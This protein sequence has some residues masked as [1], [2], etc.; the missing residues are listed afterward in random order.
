[1]SKRE[2]DG[3]YRP[4]HILWV[5]RSKGC[6]DISKVKD[7]LLNLHPLPLRKRYGILGTLAFESQIL[8]SPIYGETRK[9]HSFKWGPEQERVWYKPLAGSN[10]MTYYPLMVLIPEIQHCVASLVSRARSH[11][12]IS[13]KA[14]LGMPLCLTETEVIN[15]S[16][17]YHELGVTGFTKSL[18]QIVK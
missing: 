12:F 11:L 4:L 14:T 18:G 2:K 5:Q 17:P 10:Y 15:W 1:M 8:L 3:S 6:W 7:K 9:V 16:C 13:W